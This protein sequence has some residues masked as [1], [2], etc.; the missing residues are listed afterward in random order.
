MLSVVVDDFDMGVN[1]IIR[2]DDHFNN[3]F[4]QYFIYKN[5]NWQIPKYAHIPL[6]HG[7]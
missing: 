3:V 4:R 1:L 7:E 5:M 2:G 6:I